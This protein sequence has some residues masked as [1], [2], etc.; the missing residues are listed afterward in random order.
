MRRWIAVGLE[1]SICYSIFNQNL[2]YEKKRVTV[3]VLVDRGK[4][5]DIRESNPN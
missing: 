2:R 5:E 1:E 4:Q 3:G